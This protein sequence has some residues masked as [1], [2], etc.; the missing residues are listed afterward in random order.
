G[1]KLSLNITGKAKKILAK[2]GFDPV[3]GARPLKRV[4]QNEVQNVLAMKLLNGEI[5]EG[6]KVTVDVAGPEGR[7]LDFKVKK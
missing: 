3:Y 1:K 7:L 4:I 5:K 2:E 6:D